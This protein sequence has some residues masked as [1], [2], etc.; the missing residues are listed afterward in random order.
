MKS[1]LVK[2]IA[3]FCLIIVIALILKGIFGVTKIG[4]SNFSSKLPILKCE[5]FDIDGSKK[6][7]FYDLEKIKKNDPTQGMTKDQ[8]Q[9]WRKQKYLDAVTFGENEFMNNYTIKY[10]YHENG[11]NKGHGITINK[12]TGVLEARFPKH[13]SVDADINEMLNAVVDGKL[14]KGECVE[15]KRKNL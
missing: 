2:I 1:N 5:I 7:E 9:K 10:R 13:I 15:I 14:F 3:T 4:I 8:I 12:E 11:I 6:I